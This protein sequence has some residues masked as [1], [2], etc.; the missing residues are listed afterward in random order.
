MKKYKISYK[1]D[2][3][4]VVEASSESAA[5]N[6]AQKLSLDASKSGIFIAPTKATKFKLEQVNK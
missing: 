2:V 5:A 6:K 1:A 4:I 3:S